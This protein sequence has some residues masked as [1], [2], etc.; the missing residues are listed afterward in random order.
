MKL[1][2][3]KPFAVAHRAALLLWA[4]LFALALSSGGAEAFPIN[5][6][7]DKNSQD[8]NYDI[9]ATRS[10]AGVWKVKGHPRDIF[11]RVV[12]IKMEGDK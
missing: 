10:F 4:T 8:R 6:K 1:I 5:F 7:K 2:E 12:T 9:V 11:H 3:K